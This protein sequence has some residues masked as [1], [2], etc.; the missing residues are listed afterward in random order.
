MINEGS[1][2]P[3]EPRNNAEFMLMHTI[4]LGMHAT[5]R[6]IEDV[7]LVFVGWMSITIRVFTRRE[8]GEDQLNLGH[9]LMGLITIRFFMFFANLQTSLSF[10]PGIQPLAEARTVNRTFVLCFI[11]VTVIHILRIG[12]RNNQHIPWHSHNFGV[13][14]LD[15]MLSLPSFTI[16]GIRV[17][18][19]DGLLYR[20]IEPVLCYA[21]IWFLLPDSF[22]R[23]YLLWASLALMIH[24][25]LVFNTRRKKH[26]AAINAE[27]ESSVMKQLRDE[28]FGAGTPS[29]TQ[30][31]GFP[32]TPIPPIMETLGIR[33]GDIEAT[34][35]ETM[36][37]NEE[38][39][40]VN[41]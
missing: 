41:A 30:T 22:T 18:V 10:I 33:P 32:V 35:A 9:G 36:G 39:A 37:T 17:Q 24:N 31:M 8:F 1:S 2:K 19:S 34:V 11:A 21:V 25:N 7:I 20:V 13:S 26:L 27:I 6:A 4:P 23:N 5:L 28:A 29:V 16:K 14:W 12:W 38:T 40:T 3:R 15:W